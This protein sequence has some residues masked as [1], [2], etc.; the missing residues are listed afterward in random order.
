MKFITG[1]PVWYISGSTILR[2]PMP[3]ITTRRAGFPAPPVEV[4]E[5]HLAFVLQNNR[6]TIVRWMMQQTQATVDAVLQTAVQIRMVK[7]HRVTIANWTAVGPAMPG[8]WVSPDGDTMV[9]MQTGEVL[10]KNAEFR[11]VP[12]SMAAFADFEAIFGKE[13]LQCAH[14]FQHTNR[15]WVEI[16]NSNHELMEWTEHD[17]KDQGVGVPAPVP[18]LAFP[19]Q[20]DRGAIRSLFAR[21]APHLVN[22]AGNQ[23]PFADCLIAIYFSR[24]SCGPCRQFTPRLA[25]CHSALKRRG[26]NF[27][28]VWISVDETEEAAQ[29]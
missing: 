22:N 25:D 9:N 7:K 4:P 5:D 11:P 16:I 27:E 19:Q 28:V 1:A 29:Q 26:A 24:H 15:T 20:Q 13:S 6:A 23:T 12:E 14:R 10:L 2:V 18:S 21:A 3:G 17:W 8:M